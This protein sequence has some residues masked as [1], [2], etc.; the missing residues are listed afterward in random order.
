[1]ADA[2]SMDGESYGVNCLICMSG[3]VCVPSINDE[4]EVMA[5]SVFS[6]YVFLEATAYLE[7]LASVI[8]LSWIAL[9]LLRFGMAVF[10]CHFPLSLGFAFLARHV[11]I[12]AF[13]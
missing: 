10:L 4:T 9:G 13:P 5:A 2:I 1:M 6:S 11:F 3:R 8:L 7:L 12:C